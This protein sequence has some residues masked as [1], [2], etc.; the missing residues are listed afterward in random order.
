LNI[1]P[2]VLLR[3]IFLYLVTSRHILKPSAANFPH[4]IFLTK[5]SLKFY[6]LLTVHLGIILVNDQPDAQFFFYM[7]I[8]IL[9]MFRAISC[10]SSGESIVP[11]QL[12]VFF[13]LCRCPASM[14]VGKELSSF[15]TCMP[16]EVARFLSRPS[17]Q[18]DG[19]LHRVTY[20]RRCIDTIDSPDDEHEVA[21]NM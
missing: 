12:L 4:K 18:T 1:A 5:I 7:F 9:Y 20:T 8:S 13:T 6:V 17:Y 10:S 21:R 2:A 16:D 11:I 3:F 15:L 14:Q 19:H